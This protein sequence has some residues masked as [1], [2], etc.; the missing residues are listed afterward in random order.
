MY[1]GIYVG[2]YFIMVLFLFAAG[3]L[4]AVTILGPAAGFM[5][6]SIMLRF[7]VDI[8]KPGSKLYLLS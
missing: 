5:L 3:I 7:Y 1:A 4:F 6:G 8:D 2:I